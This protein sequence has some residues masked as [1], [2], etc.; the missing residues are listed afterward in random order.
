MKLIFD[1]D[2][3]EELEAGIRGFSDV[4]TIEVESGSPGEPIEPTD[5]EDYFDGFMRSCLAQWFDGAKVTLRAE[6]K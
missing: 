6:T 1:I 2:M 3:P 4:V 5:P